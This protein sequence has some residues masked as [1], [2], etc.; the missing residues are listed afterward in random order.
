MKIIN[1]SES[2]E[3]NWKWLAPN[4]KD[5]EWLNYSSHNYPALKSLPKHETIGRMAA[6]L[7]ACSKAKKDQSIL[8]AHG[9]KLCL[10]TG[11]NAATIC[12]DVP[13]LAFTFSFTNLPQGKK[14][15]FAIKASKH[16]KKFVCSTTMERALYAK[17]FDIPIEKIDMVHWTAEAPTID[18]STPPIENGRYFCALG[19]QGRDYKILIEAMKKLPHIQCVVV[20]AAACL[21]GLDIPSNVKVHT[22]IPLKDAHNIL[23][24]SEFMV[25]PL[26]HSDT[27][28]GHMTIV[29]SMFFRKTILST[30][31]ES[32]YDYIENGKTGLY[33]ED[34]DVQDLTHKIESLWGDP[35]NTIAMNDA[36]FAF[37]Q[38]HCTEKVAVDYFSNFVKQYA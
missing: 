12:P 7:Q 30:N 11:F 1:V 22:N 18:L 8:V 32:V 25:L 26:G 29:S 28:T 2:S 35:N 3:P 10:F 6:T 5:Y 27:P 19:S 20:A 4:F 24:H 36:A 13:L 31:T 17:Y 21:N 37:A 16:P 15:S 34:N 23:S 38:E 9:H 14:R 33:F